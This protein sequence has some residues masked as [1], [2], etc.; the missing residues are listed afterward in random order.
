MEYITAHVDDRNRCNSS[1]QVLVPE[2]RLSPG[3]R[4][5]EGERGRGEGKGQLVV[6][7][8]EPEAL[9]AV[10]TAIIH[11]QDATSEPTLLLLRQ[12]AQDDDV[13]R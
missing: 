4:R 12:R 7:G 5:G 10:V 1:Q 2:M 8:A 11:G 9:D 3:K 6:V 13:S